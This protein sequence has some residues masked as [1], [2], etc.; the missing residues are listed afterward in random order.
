MTKSSERLNIL[1]A[2]TGSRCFN[3][4]PLVRAIVLDHIPLF[5]FRTGGP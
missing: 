1:S 4:T 5:H 2:T 3:L